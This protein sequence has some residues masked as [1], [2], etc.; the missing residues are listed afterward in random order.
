M[1]ILRKCSSDGIVPDIVMEQAIKLHSQGMNQRVIAHAP[2][3][4]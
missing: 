1:D 3:I 2:L 4:Y